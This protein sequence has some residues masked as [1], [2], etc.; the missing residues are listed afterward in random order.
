MAKEETTKDPIEDA[1]K[2]EVK[3]SPEAAE[4][5]ESCDEYKN[6]WKR[7]LA[8]YENLK[9]DLFTQKEGARRQIKVSFVQDL[10]PVM[11]NYAQAIAHAPKDLPKEYDTWMQGVTFIQK[12][13][14]DVLA[15][16]GVELIE[17]GDEFDPNL[18][19][20][21]GEGDEMKEVRAGWK[22]GDHVIR[23]A[24]VIVKK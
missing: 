21:V 5:C 15:G 9:R 14:A 11:D 22:I 1:E 13:F 20:S 4:G 10:L 8:D 3:E 16:L 12:Q 24:Q 17:I 2:D 7:A 23:P 19:E 18:H 6:G